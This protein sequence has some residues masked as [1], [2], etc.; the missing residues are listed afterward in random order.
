M[1]RKMGSAKTH[2][3]PQQEKHHVTSVE[4][5]INNTAP[6]IGRLQAR[7]RGNVSLEPKQMCK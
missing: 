1:E 3:Y 5:K 7:E 6:T 4:A 2:T